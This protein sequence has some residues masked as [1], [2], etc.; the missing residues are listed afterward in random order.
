[1]TALIPEAVLP[2]QEV[3]ERLNHIFTRLCFAA[4]DVAQIETVKREAPELFAATRQH[5]SHIPPYGNEF[6]AEAMLPWSTFRTLSLK[7]LQTLHKTRHTDEGRA[8]ITALEEVR[9]EMEREGANAVDSPTSISEVF[10]NTRWPF[11]PGAWKQY[12]KHIAQQSPVE[13]FLITSHQY[14]RARNVM[15]WSNASPEM[16]QVDEFM[17]VRNGLLPIKD[18][19]GGT[20]IIPV[21]EYG[22]TFACSLID[23]ADIIKVRAVRCLGDLA[24]E[25]AQDNEDILKEYTA[26][27]FDAAQYE[28]TYADASEKTSL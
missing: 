25:I 14:I 10:S 27:G 2:P 7:E 8:M 13:R 28:A 5:E 22:E 3:Q 12:E 1:M 26:R 19:L 11:N 4:A 21:G 15:K 6:A 20:A 18:A 24:A 16:S 23:T 17:L 9:S